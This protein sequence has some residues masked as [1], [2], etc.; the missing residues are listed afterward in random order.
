MPEEIAIS[1]RSLAVDT[2]AEGGRKV[3]H[4]A[5]EKFASRVAAQLSGLPADTTLVLQLFDDAS[6]FAQTEDGSFF[7]CS[8]EFNS[9]EYHVFGDLVL[10]PA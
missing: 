7:S 1:L 8:Q 4:V 5:E 6:Y 3:R 9:P 2:V 10:G